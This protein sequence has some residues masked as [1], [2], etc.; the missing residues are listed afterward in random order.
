MIN[1]LR[2]QEWIKSYLS[3]IEEIS[4]E[5]HVQKEEGYKFISVNNFQKHFNL[6]EPDLA[7][8]LDRAIENN[9]LVA[10][11]MH[12]P[13]KMLLIFAQEYEKETRAILENLFNES[14]NIAERI[15]HAE[16]SFNDLMQRRNERLNEEAKSFIGLRFLSLLLGFRYPNTSN[17]IKPR[18]WKVFC[19]FIDDE[20]NIPNGTKSGQQYEKFQP[21]I[22]ALKKE[23]INIPQIRSLHDQLTRGLDFTDQEYHWMT[24]DVIYVTAR[25][26]AAKKS[27]EEVPT[28]AM[29]AAA[30]VENEDE[31]PEAVEMAFPLEKYL[32]HFIVKNWNSIDFGEHLELYVDEDGTPGEQYTTDVG[33][34]DILAKDKDGNFVVI[35]LKRGVSNQN[36]IGQILSY[37]SW[38][39][40]NLSAKGQK[41][42]GIVIVNEGNKALLAA[43]KEVADKVAVKYYRVKFDIIDPK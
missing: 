20:F 29:E 18:E 10:G 1:Q 36:V 2:I 32:E 38:V 3:H 43:Q 5:T 27:G 15:N 39:R 34:I 31:L 13:R 21:C 9:N 41:V 26:L 22:E 11:N 25:V 14:K 16:K 24:Q 37:I 4:P 19:K 28:Q 40:E 17:A 42:R 8:M 7:A 33:I 12:F 6:N 35:E 30:I 23:I